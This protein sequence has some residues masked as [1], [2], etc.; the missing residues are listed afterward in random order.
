M[1]KATRS[2]R[3]LAAAAWQEELDRRA[4]EQEEQERLEAERLERQIQEH[5]EQL[6]RVIHARFGIARV[7]PSIIRTINAGDDEHTVNHHAFVYDD[8]A[9]D[10]GAKFTTEPHRRLML[11]QQCPLCGYWRVQSDSIRHL[12]DLG[13]ALAADKPIHRSGGF[14]GSLDYCPAER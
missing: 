12:T 7:D 5:A 14:H 11:L 6:A 10:L 2:L 4:A 8:F 13:E 9:L 1:T 3:E